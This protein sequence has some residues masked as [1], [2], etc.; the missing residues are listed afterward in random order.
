MFK[1]YSSLD[2]RRNLRYDGRELIGE[3][4]ILTEKRDGQCVPIWVNENN[5]V[6]IGSRNKMVAASNIQARMRSTPEWP[7]VQEFIL[8]EKNT[9]NHPIVVYGELDKKISPTR[10]EMRKK[11]LHYTL[12]DIW[13]INTERYIG[14]NWIYQ[15]GSHFNIPVVRIVDEFI[16]K[17]IEHLDGK[18]EEAIDWSKRHHREGVVGKCYRK[19]IMFK[20]KRDLPKRKKVRDDDD[21]KPQLPPMPPEKC[22]RALLN[23]FVEV[24]EENWSDVSIAMPVVAN[25]FSAEASEHFFR[26]PKDLYRWYKDIPVEDLKAGEYDGR[27]GKVEEK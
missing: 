18:L 15:R 23:A 3:H 24:G 5:E 21:D 7:K 13:D 1:K 4:I 14:Y 17:S 8:E 19:Q 20:H 11:H 22:F 10:C 16:V 26:R 27:K 9:Y 6:I 12:F 25:H 2:H